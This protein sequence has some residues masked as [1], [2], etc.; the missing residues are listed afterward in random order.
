M[1]NK[2]HIFIMC[3]CLGISVTML[4][5]FVGCQA[6]SKT[7]TLA[8]EQAG[9]VSTIADTLSDIS[10]DV[11]SDVNSTISSVVSSTTDTSSTTTS[12]VTSKVA[13]SETPTSKINTSTSTASSINNAKTEQIQK[14]NERYNQAIK[15]INDYMDQQRQDVLNKITKDGSSV[16]SETSEHRKIQL[17]SIEDSRKQQTTNQNQIHSDNLKTI[18]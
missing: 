18:G 12:K 14:E 7:A 5:S 17:S 10:S 4:L 13:S 8:T 15:N 6:K 3:L 16:N 9:D 11:S 2:N 1:K